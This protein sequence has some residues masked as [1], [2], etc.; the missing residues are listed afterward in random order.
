MK[1]NPRLSADKA[2]WLASRWARESPDGQWRIQGQP[3][4][5]LVSA[6]LPRL[7]EVMALYSHVLT[8]RFLH[9]LGC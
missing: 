7:E 6:N 9:R 1:T 2:Q 3:G 5:K 8:Q 4:H